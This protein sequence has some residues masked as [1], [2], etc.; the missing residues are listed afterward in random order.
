MLDDPGALGLGDLAGPV[1]RA[2][3]DDEDLV[4]ERDPA[5]HLAH[6]PADDR[7]D[8]LLL[9]ERRQDERDRQALLLLELDEAAEIGELGVVEVRLAEP[10]LD[11][12]RDG[13]RLL[14]GPVG[15][16]ERLGPRGELLE[17]LA[18]D[19]LAGLDDDDGRLRPGR[20]RLRQGTEQVGLAVGAGR[21]GRRAH[22][23]E[24]GLLGLAQDRV[25]DVRR[26]ADDPLAAAAEVLADELGEGVLRLGAD[27]ERDPGRDEV[28]DADVGVVA[29]GDR[30]GVAD[31]QLGVGTAADRDDDPPDLLAAA[32][33]DDGDVGRRVADDLVDRR[34]EDRRPAAVAPG[35]RLPAPAEDDEVGLLL[36]RR[37][38]DALGGVPADPDDR[39]DRRP[40]RARSRGPAGG[41]GGRGGPGSRPRT[42]A[43]PRAPRRCRARS[44]RRPAGRGG[45][46]RGGS[47][48]RPSR[49][50]RPG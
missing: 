17:R 14:G 24:V 34:R 16:G 47:A 29:S 26:L 15:G 43:C 1:G 35:R 31:R 40:L 45:T 36:G 32:L 33:L 38:D 4:E 28:E 50:W 41:G 42:A 20:D 13:A 18:A 27:G 10:A 12:G 9:V 11:P 23:D 2:G 46:T 48:P 3:V 39:V 30:V 6:R 44:A 19:H 7:A 22:D 5:H 25:A 37:L 8:R 21:L 49:G